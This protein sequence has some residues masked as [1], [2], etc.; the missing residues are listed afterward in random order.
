[1]DSWSNSTIWSKKRIANAAGPF[2]SRFS[3]SHGTYSP[4]VRDVTGTVT[5]TV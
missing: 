3:S 5:V 4:H 1:M 2:K